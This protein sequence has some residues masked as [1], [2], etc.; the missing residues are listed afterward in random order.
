MS[1]EPIRYL[2]GNGKAAYVSTAAPLPVDIQ[3]ATLSLDAAG[4]E[5]ANDSGNPIP[6]S[7][8]AGSLTVDT[9]AYGPSS[10]SITRPADTT[11]YAAGDVVSNS[12][13]APTVL[14]FAS[15]GP[16][17]GRVVLQ[18]ASLRIDVAAVPSG[19][20]SFRLHLYTS[21]PTAINDNAAFN[22]PSA[23]RAKY[24]GY[25]EFS[26]PQGLGDTL[27]SQVEYIGR[28]I[29][30]D[31]ASTSLYGILETRGAFTPSSAAVKTIKISALEA[32]R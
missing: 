30:L 22:L 11:A 1:D 13:S 8:N 24:A 29:K 2:D 6:V 9:V 14:E 23:D 5:I 25:I 26:T 18:S 17:G 20:S 32:G 21:S 27:W 12:T 31:T 28:Q 4:V 10:V 3:G 7:D 19:M 16:S 15:I